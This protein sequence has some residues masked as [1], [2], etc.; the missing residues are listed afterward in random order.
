MRRIPPWIPVP[1]LGFIAATLVLSLL[2]GDTYPEGKLERPAPMEVPD[3]DPVF[4]RILPSQFVHACP[5]CGECTHPVETLRNRRALSLPD[6][7]GW[8]K[9]FWA[10]DDLYHFEDPVFLAASMANP[11][12]GE[13]RGTWSIRARV[14]PARHGDS[15]PHACTAAPSEIA[16]DYELV[17]SEPPIQEARAGPSALFAQF[18][19][20]TYGYHVARRPSLLHFG[21]RAVPPPELAAL[22]CPCAKP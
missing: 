13:P 3:D 12:A 19:W 14:G 18:D 8:F 11:T 15:G 4:R 16:L 17:V 2:E 7:D 20:F 21:W 5:A 1:A 6:R 10:G 9:L 22:P